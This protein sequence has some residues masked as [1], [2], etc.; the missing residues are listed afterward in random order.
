MKKMIIILGS[1]V[2]IIGIAL[3][4]AG[5]YFYNVAIAINDKDFLAAEPDKKND[6]WKIQKEWYQTAPREERSIL[7]DDGLKLKAIYIP[8]ATPSKKTV[9]LAHGYSGNYEQ[10][11]PYAKLFH[12]W[13]Y[14]ILA[15]DARGHGKSEGSYIGFGWHERKDY[16]KW[17]DLMIDQTGKDT[18][19]A[20]FGVSMGGATVMMT[21]G[22]ELPSNVK[23]IV[24]DCGYSSVTDE[25]AYQLKDMYRLPSFPLIPVTSV[26]TKFKAGYSFGEASAVDQL[27]KNKTPM[28]FIHGDKDLF[29]PTEMVYK[30]YEATTAPKELY[31]VKG[32]GHA[33]AYVKDKKGYEKEVHDFI[34]TYIK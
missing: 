15:P 18:E 28:L 10:M 3:F 22:E 17:I 20:L 24:E 16:L 26:V 30:N 2:V 12:D 21:S 23:V 6:P 13:G 1:L 31:I 7:S 33:E 25:L 9:I 11:S 32:A 14:N 8:A 4:G 19:L 5:M 27:K 29:V 34:S